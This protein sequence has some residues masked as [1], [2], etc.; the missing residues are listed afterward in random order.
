MIS[1]QCNAKTQQQT[2]QISENEFFFKNVDLADNHSRAH[3]GIG[4]L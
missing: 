1:A 3:V 2:F 4:P